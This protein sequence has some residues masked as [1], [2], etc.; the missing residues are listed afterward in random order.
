[1]TTDKQVVANRANAQ[2]STGPRT[3]AGKANS[4][5]NALKHGL[6]AAQLLIPGED[7]REYDEFCALMVEEIAP[8]GHLEAALAHRLVENIW[9]L[10][11]VPLLENA[12][13]AWAEA[14]RRGEPEFDV[15]IDA[16]SPHP[17]TW[18]GCP[19]DEYGTLKLLGRT[20]HDAL[21]NNTLIK[22]S[23]YEARLFRLVERLLAQLDGL[24][25]RRETDEATEAERRE[26]TGP[27]VT[28]GESLEA[29]WSTSP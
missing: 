1:M 22:L 7:A 11:R 25:V 27:L 19:K 2:S 29:P 21:A 10:R 12:F 5:A 18:A 20:V 26:S 9:R 23:A 16:L 13:F 28:D 8:G 4:R 14:Q 3:Q 6:S 15:L 24:R 17:K